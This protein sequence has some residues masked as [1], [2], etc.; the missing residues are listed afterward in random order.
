MEI[1]KHKGKSKMRPT[2]KNICCILLAVM[3]FCLSFGCDN[4]SRY[5][6][7]EK[8]YKSGYEDGY[9]DGYADGHDDGVE[10]GFDAGYFDAQYEARHK[11][12]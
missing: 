6:I 5:E 1:Q 10:E 11:E 4:R 8:A 3:F 9:E 2:V 7:E 12:D